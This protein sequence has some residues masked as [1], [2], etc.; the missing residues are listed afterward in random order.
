[1]VKVSVIVPVYNT[2]IYLEKCLLSLVSQTLEDIEIIVINDGTP[3]NSQKIIDNYKNKYPNIKSYI[4]KN[5]GLS[6]TR[7]YGINIANGEYISFID[8]DDYIKN[9]MLEK[10]YN[11]AN[12]NDLD[13]VVCDTVKVYPE[14]N[15]QIML[16]SNLK[17]SEDVIKNYLIAPPMACIRLFKKEILK[18]INFKKDI[19]YEDLELCPKVVNYTKKIGFVEEPLYFYLQRKGS[20]MKQNDFNEKLLD[21]FSVLKSNKDVLIN[22]YPEEIEYMFITHLL[23]TAVLRFLSYKNS[24]KYLEEINKIMKNDFPHWQKNKYYQKSSLKLKILCTLA[25]HKQYKLLKIIKIIQ[26]KKS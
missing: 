16:K 1:M 3:D 26:N 5:G 6:D 24:E 19:Y 9:N 15:T 7:N 2:E 12:R 23:R 25:Y 13:I 8:S 22:D 18:K 17:Y 10:M 11:Y 4:K 14:N 21:I 20:I